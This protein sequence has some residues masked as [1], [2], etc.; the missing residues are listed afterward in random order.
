[1]MM[2]GWWCTYNLMNWWCY[3][4]FTET[5]CLRKRWI[6]WMC[7]YEMEIWNFWKC[8]ANVGSDSGLV[9]IIDQLIELANWMDTQ[10]LDI[11][12]LDLL[13]GDPLK[14]FFSFSLSF[15]FLFLSFKFT[16]FNHTHAPC[17]LVCVSAHQQLQQQQQPCPLCSASTTTTT[18]SCNPTCCHCHCP[19]N[20][21]NNPRRLLNSQQRIEM[22]PP[23]SLSLLSFSLSK[24]TTTANNNNHAPNRQQSPSFKMMLM[25]T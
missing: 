4:W 24:R 21:K 10:Q 5:V 18:T 12:A 22:H 17:V 7:D 15:L 11:D 3:G 6:N 13:L 20:N 9:S 19:N 14:M 23:L 8:G 2:M 1:M 16:I 25:V